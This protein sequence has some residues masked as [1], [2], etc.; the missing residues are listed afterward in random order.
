MKENKNS[1]KID[2]DSNEEENGLVHLAEEYGEIIIK[3]IKTLAPDSE[4]D[5]IEKLKQ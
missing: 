2:K 4:E 5:D 3:A 1:E